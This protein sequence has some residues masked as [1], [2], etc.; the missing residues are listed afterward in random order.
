[1]LLSGGNRGTSATV[2][3]DVKLSG[4]VATIG[5]GVLQDVSGR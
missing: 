4:K 2:T 1:M 5:Q 3:T